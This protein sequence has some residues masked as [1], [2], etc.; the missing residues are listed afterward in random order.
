M[1]AKTRSDSLKT[2]LL[3]LF[4]LVEALDEEVGHALN[5]PRAID[6]AEHRMARC[7]YLSV[8]DDFVVVLQFC[9]THTRQLRANGEFV[10]IASGGSKA[11]LSPSDDKKKSRLFHR[12]IV[13]ALSAIEFGSTDF[14]KRKVARVM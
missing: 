3:Q 10:V 13:A 11:A 6:A 12:A 14:E 7:E 2:L 5:L 1:L 4:R 9:G 8:A